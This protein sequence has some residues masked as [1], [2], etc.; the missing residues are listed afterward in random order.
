MAEQLDNIFLES[1]QPPTEEQKRRLAAFAKRIHQTEAPIIWRQNP[2]LN[3]GFRLYVGVNVYD[4]S[5][6]G[7]MRQFREKMLNLCHNFIGIIRW[8][9]ATFGSSFTSHHITIQTNKLHLVGDA[10]QAKHNAA[11]INVVIFPIILIL[12]P[13]SVRSNSNIMN[14]RTKAQH[15][16]THHQHN[17]RKQ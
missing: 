13:M 16:L 12:R 3:S 15:A 14:I 2:A 4:W 10:R 5:L 1:A 11:P 17:K 8:C 7:R 9:I 6:E